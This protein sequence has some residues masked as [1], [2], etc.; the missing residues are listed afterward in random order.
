M[1]GDWVRRTIR[2]IEERRCAN[3]GF[4][5]YRLDEP[6]GSDTY[7]A[8]ATL[9]LLGK[10]IQDPSTVRFLQDS[11][12][13]DGSF[14]NLYQAYYT[15]KGLQ[16]METPPRFDSRPYLRKQLNHFLVENAL[17]ET[18]LKRL[19][20]L[21]ELCI[22]SGIEIKNSQRRGISAFILS[23][24]EGHGGFGKPVPTLLAS[25][26]A[27]VCLRRLNSDVDLSDLFPFVASCEN[28]THGFLNVPH[29]APSFL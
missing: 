1:R 15:L 4:C 19:D 25:A 16:I 9:H 28:P 6:N 27:A 22:D 14:H 7:F 21:T 11:Q 17:P 2:Y 29:M 20:H 8:I 23:L 26:L 3:G 12:A 13:P 18:A 24:K 10:K 5:F